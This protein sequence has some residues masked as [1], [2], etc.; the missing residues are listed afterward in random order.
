MQKIVFHKLL[1]FG[2]GML[3]LFECVMRRAGIPAQQQRY[4]GSGT[5]MN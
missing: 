3:G 1:G 4:N 5:A 2:M